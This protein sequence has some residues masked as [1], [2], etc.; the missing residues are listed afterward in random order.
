MVTMVLGDWRDNLGKFLFMFTLTCL[1]LLVITYNKKFD[2]LAKLDY[3][4]SL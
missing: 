1:I 3:D 4:T 2:A